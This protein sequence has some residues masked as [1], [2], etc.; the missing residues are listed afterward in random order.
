VNHILVDAH[1]KGASDIHIEPGLRDQPVQIRYRVDGLCHRV[2]EVPN[3]FKRAILSRV[4]IM[5]DLDIAERRRPQSG[6]ILMKVSDQRVEYRVEIT[7]TAGGNEDAVL[8]ILSSA[9]P[10]SLDAMLFSPVNLKR[11]KEILGQPHGLILCV[12][13]TGSGKTTTLH[14][15][16]AYINTPERK[17]WT[18][19]DPVEITQDGLRQVQ[20]QPKIGLTFAE[21]LRSFLRADPDVIMVGEMRDFDA[22]KIAIEA[23]LTGHL[24]LSTLHTNS[25]AETIVRLIEMGV[26]PLN[27]ADALL[28]ILAQRLTRRLC[29][30]CKTATVVSPEELQEIREV[31][32]PLW[33]DRHQ[34]PASPQGLTLMRARGCAHCGRSGYQGRIALHELLVGTEA[35]KK[36]VKKKAPADELKAVALEDGMRTL[37]MD[38]I[39]KVL[40]GW[41]DLGQVLKVCAMQTTSDLR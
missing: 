8:R 20:L 39:G 6:K 5:A 23:S 13:P 10:I 14:S 24:V 2:H 33:Y 7:P 25:A 21:V 34:L 11:M 30:A 41:T 4:K 22:A 37:L 28:G 1:G 40:Q 19:E 16:L 32:D 38:G 18:V 27:C 36:A 17:I 35:I 29:P 3:S 26:D 9:R 31:Y 12:G 15:A